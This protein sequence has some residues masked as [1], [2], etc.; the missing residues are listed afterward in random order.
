MNCLYTAQGDYVCK[1]STTEYGK[2]ILEG[3]VNTT[4]PPAPMPSPA[5]APMPSPAPAPMPTPAPPVT[6]SVA[7]K[8]ADPA[9]VQK[10]ASLLV[11]QC[12]KKGNNNNLEVINSFTGYAQCENALVQAKNNICNISPSCVLGTPPR[13]STLKTCS[14]DYGPDWRKK[15]LENI[16]ASPL[17][18]LDGSETSLIKVN[19]NEIRSNLRVRELPDANVAK[20]DDVLRN[21]IF[22]CLS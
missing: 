2:S 13:G 14:P 18:S 20:V 8:A 3:F 21:N 6:S 10:V 12:Y 9:E 16:A 11:S 19:P 4:T 17:N 5:P 22:G 1:K 7:P 15:T